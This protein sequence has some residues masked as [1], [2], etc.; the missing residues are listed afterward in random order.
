MTSVHV[1][2]PASVNDPCRPS[3]GNTYDRKVCEGLVEVGWTV[4]VHPVP[5][6]WPVP[7]RAATRALARVVAAVPDGDVVL[8]DGLVASVAA[9]VLVPESGR[10]R[11]VVIVHL[12]AGAPAV[13]ST[14]SAVAA[15]EKRV[16]S[17]AV[18]VVTPSDWTRR[19]L[20]QS[21]HLSP[22][23]VHVAEPGVDPSP[24]ASGTP[25]GGELLCVG[26]VAR[27]K[28]HDLLLAALGGVTELSWRCVW[29]GSLDVDP[30]FA[31]SLLR[32]AAA[33]GLGDRVV[34]AGPLAG[35]QLADAYDTA[36]LL[37][38][39]SRM[40][41]YG[42]VAT[43]ALGRGLPVIAPAVGGIPE[44]LGTT[45]DGLRPG[46]LVTPQDPGALAAALRLWLDDAGLRQRLRQAALERRRTLPTWTQT[47]AQVSRVLVKASR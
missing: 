16:L 45:A 12:P 38:L 39:A 1:V 36:D 43:E 23:R 22:A 9:D 27:H 17:G 10:V 40:E 35:R 11:Q 41:T 31:R 37:V 21:Y 24:A 13:G 14:P 25:D 44:A 32:D 29:A 26:A 30:A 46:M 34:F 8:L 19:W 2:V 4:R 42:M 6:S 7:D 5:G 3:G 18:A 33:C 28:G 15:A 47:T 20:V